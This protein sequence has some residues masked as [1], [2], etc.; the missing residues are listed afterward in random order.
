MAD[1]AASTDTAPA[2]SAEVRVTWAE[3]Y[4]DLVFVFAVTE[5]STLLRG[6]GTWLGVAHAMVVFVPIY[7]VW[8]GT[9]VFANTHD[10]DTVVNRLG[11]L[12]LG[13]IGLFMALA[14]PFAYHSRGVLFGVA[15]LAARLVLIGL[16]RHS[17]GI[18]ITYLVA[19]GVSA[20]LLV[21]GGFLP[22]PVRLLVWAAAAAT[23]LA[24][25]ALAR[26]RLERVQF[27]PGHLAERFGGFLIIALGES[28]VAIGAP[29]AAAGRLGVDVLA[30]VAAAFVL[31]SG[32]W[33]VY[34]VFAASAVRHALETAPN[35]GD[36]IRRVLSYGHLSF[37]GAIIAVAVGLAGVIAHPGGRLNPGEAGLLF[38][39]SALYLATFGYTRWRMFRTV[40]KT[41]LSAAAAV[42]LPLP[43]ATRVPA[44]A[45]LCWV[46]AVVVVLNVA[47]HWIVRRQSR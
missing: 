13:L 10:I 3:L 24:T 26:G 29:A 31:A 25:P 16:A 45:A 19:V 1:P 7:W 2:E 39:G 40:S 35:R 12:A 47:E 22:P 17:G 11:I 9:C 34:Y 15:Y 14:T 46:A 33:W 36:I 8:V 18:P 43:V 38:G 41:R 23:D 5:V 20:P 42:V 28:I 37:I 21:L 30:A 6:E 27:A 4:F 32:L 44:L